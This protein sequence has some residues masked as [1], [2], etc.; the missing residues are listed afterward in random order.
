MRIMRLLIALM[1]PI[2]LHILFITAEKG[3]SSEDITLSDL[4]L[5]IP[6]LP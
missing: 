1:W 4:G 3:R 5:C 2:L 6:E